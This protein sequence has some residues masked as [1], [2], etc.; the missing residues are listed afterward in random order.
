MSDKYSKNLKL[1]ATEISLIRL[2][3]ENSILQQKECLLKEW[4]LI[5]KSELQ[6]QLKTL[7]KLEEKFFKLTVNVEKEVLKDIK[8]ITKTNN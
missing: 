1:T 2:S 6:T 5:P 7:E 3:L 4:E 8:K